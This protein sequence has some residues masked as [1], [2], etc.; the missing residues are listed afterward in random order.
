MKFDIKS[1]VPLIRRQKN[2]NEIIRIFY[3]ETYLWNKS[4]IFKLF[5]FRITKNIQYPITWKTRKYSR[6]CKN[7]FEI[8]EKYCSVRG[9]SIQ[10]PDPDSLPGLVTLGPE[11]LM[12]GWALFSETV[13]CLISS[14]SIQKV[15]GAVW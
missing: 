9:W 1:L 7:L 11:I 5:F 10:I 8:H 6:V 3:L 15:H 13:L 4:L 14:T 12:I 2:R